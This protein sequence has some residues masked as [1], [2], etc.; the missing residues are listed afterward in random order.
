MIGSMPETQLQEG[1]RGPALENK[2]SVRTARE[3]T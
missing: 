3:I 2:V 1:V